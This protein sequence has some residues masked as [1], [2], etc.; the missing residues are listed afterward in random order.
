MSLRLTNDPAT[1]PGQYNHTIFN[2]DWLLVDKVVYEGLCDLR[3]IT[4]TPDDAYVVVFI[5]ELFHVHLRSCC[6]LYLFYVGAA[7]A[8]R[9][10]ITRMSE[11]EDSGLR[12]KIRLVDFDTFFTQFRVPGI[13]VNKHQTKGCFLAEWR[14]DEMSRATIIYCRCLGIHSVY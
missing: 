1:G 7:A 14:G 11:I 12:L 13:A 4:P 5:A 2:V 6:P 10:N 9:Q 8:W 3:G